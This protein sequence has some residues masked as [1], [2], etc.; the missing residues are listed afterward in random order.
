M[1]RLLYI[2]AYTLLPNHIR[3]TRFLK[4]YFGNSVNSLA[5]AIQPIIITAL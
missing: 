4:N 2:H 5:A 3:Y 1:S